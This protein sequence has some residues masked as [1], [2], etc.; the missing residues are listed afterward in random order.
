MANENDVIAFG[1]T[2]KEIID[3]VGEIAKDRVKNKG[4]TRNY[5]EYAGTMKKGRDSLKTQKKYYSH[6]PEPKNTGGV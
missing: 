3:T 4:D 2:R 6:L 1:M 5:V